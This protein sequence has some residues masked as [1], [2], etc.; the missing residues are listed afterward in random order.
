MDYSLVVGVDTLKNELVIGIVGEL[1]TELLSVI[2]GDSI[3]RLY[4]NIHLGQETR[5]LGEGNHLPWRTR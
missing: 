4:S 1:D 3:P 5:E 2:A